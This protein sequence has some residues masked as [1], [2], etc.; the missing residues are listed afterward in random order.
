M[1]ALLTGLVAA[2][3]PA[4]PPSKTGTMA[5]NKKKAPKVTASATPS[6]VAALAAAAGPNSGVRPRKVVGTEAPPV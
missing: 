4:S 1:V 2:T 6:P 5:V 3:D